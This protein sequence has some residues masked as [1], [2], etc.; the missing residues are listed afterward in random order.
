MDEE[1]RMKK[2]ALSRIC[3]LLLMCSMMF[4]FAIDVK[5]EGEDLKLV[6]GSYLTMEDSSTGTARNPLLRGEYLMD[7]D[8][9]ISK[10]GVGRIYAYG[11][12][13]ANT[14]VDFVS[15][16]VYVDQYNEE[17]D[18]WEQIDTW[19]EEATNTY[20]V[21][22]S[23]SLKVDRGY[24]YRVRCSH[25]AGDEDDRPYDTAISYTDGIYIP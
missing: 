17:D 19:T 7:G 23:K 25:F 10:A 18:V 14:T 16:V 24:Y 1:I 9:T 6:D 2:R 5:A 15:V 20:Y 3:S 21:S 11:A 22:T 12:T 8:S 13:T 4:I